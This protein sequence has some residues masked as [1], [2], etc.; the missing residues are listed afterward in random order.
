MEINVH[1]VL[2]EE[3]QEKSH[4]DAAVRIV[5]VR[6]SNDVDQALED[7]ATNFFRLE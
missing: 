1:F 5:I 6:E 2:L 3:L 4:G 7:G